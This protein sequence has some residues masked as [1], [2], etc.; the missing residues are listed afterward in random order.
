M[1][2]TGWQRGLG[3][4]AGGFSDAPPQQDS[5]SEHERQY[6]LCQGP[7]GIENTE[8][9]K[10]PRWDRASLTLV[11]VLP[12]TV[13]PSVAWGRAMEGLGQGWSSVS[14]G[15]RV[16]VGSVVALVPGAS[17]WGHGQLGQ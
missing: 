13:A 5:R 7:S 1:L 9:V 8:L 12:G 14:G 2:V 4:R 11:W 6:L 3:V 16:G 15:G 10:S 17:A